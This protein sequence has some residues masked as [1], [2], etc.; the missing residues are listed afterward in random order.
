MSEE[1]R[2]EELKKNTKQLLSGPM[3]YVRTAALAAVL[4]PLGAVAVGS[5]VLNAQCDPSDPN[6]VHVPEP[7]SVVLLG[8]GLVGLG[9]AAA[10]RLR[11]KDDDKQ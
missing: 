9:M 4:V 7:T 10:R 1:N 11:K 8:V 6:C 2:Q 3:K 5:T